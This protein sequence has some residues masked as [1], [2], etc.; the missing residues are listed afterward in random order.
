[1]AIGTAGGK[2]GCLT[3]PI[4]ALFIMNLTAHWFPLNWDTGPNWAI[5]GW[6]V[7]G[8]A[9]AVFGGLLVRWIVNRTFRIDPP[10]Y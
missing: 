9:V 8:F 4:I 3:G 6:F 2:I 10:G 5:L 1:M 7:F